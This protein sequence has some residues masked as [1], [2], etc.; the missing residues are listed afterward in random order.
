[1]LLPEKLAVC[2]ASNERFESQVGGSLSEIKRSSN[3]LQ[4]TDYRSKQQEGQQEHGMINCDCLV[5][6]SWT[7]GTALD[8]SG[9]LDPFLETGQAKL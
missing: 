1:M 5:E 3:W 2:Y 9:I 8:V 7:R 6:Y 4:R